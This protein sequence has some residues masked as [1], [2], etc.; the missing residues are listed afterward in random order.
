MEVD[1]WDAVARMAVLENAEHESFPWF[2]MERAVEKGAAL[3]NLA[4]DGD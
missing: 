1:V 3:D 4:V 2:G